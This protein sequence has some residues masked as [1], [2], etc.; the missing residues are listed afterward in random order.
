[1]RASFMPTDDE[2]RDWL[3]LYRSENVG[4]R[5]FATL[6]KC[7]GSAGSAL[8][9]LPDLAQRGGRRT[10]ICPR[11]EA[12]RELAALHRINGTLVLRGE[13]DFPPLLARADGAPPLLSMLG[14]PAALAQP[15][16]AIVGGRNAS[17]A[18]RTFANRLAA[19]LGNRDY[20]V[21]SGLARGIDAAAHEGALH[22]G[23][24]AVIAGGLDRIYPPE[25]TDL[26]R[27]IVDADGAVVSEM[28]L[29][30]TAR[31]QDFPRRNRIIAGIAQGTVLVE[32][33]MRSGSLITARLA[34]ELGREVMAAPG[35]PL[36]PRC[37]GSNRLI[38]DGATLVLTA[39]HVAEA[40]RPLA[41]PLFSAGSVEEDG[42]DGLS[43]TP[44]PP[45]DDLRAVVI[46]LLGPSPIGIDD[47][48]R[49]AEAEPRL[50]Q[51]VL[52]ELELAGRLDRQAQGRIALIS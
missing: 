20:V 42:D 9:A 7:Y 17:A 4:P 27:R 22:T 24:I 1:M 6:L 16:V 44:M 21:T 47:L 3:Q 28:P 41:L 35:S 8:E 26:V 25:H 11:A 32:A 29:G 46:G 2:R 10:R 15:S 19:S 5:A 50:I 49:H 39:D 34:A 36:D 12:E 52:L 13:P 48:I 38:R 51:T 14:N 30:W 37:E 40:L 33:A 43:G 23:T 45:P 18:G 31:A